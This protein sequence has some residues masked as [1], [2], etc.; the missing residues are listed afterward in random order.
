M[1]RQC[2]RVFATILA[3][4]LLFEGVQPLTAEAVNGVAGALDPAGQVELIVP[5]AL[6]DGGNYIFFRQV[7]YAVS[8][9]STE[10]LYLP[11]QRTGDLDEA[12][13]VTVKVIDMTARHG[14]NYELEI[15]RQDL[16]PE[17]ANADVSVLDLV[18]GAEEITEEELPGEAELGEIIY[19]AGGADIT[20]TE[21]NTI[22]SITATPLDEDGN[23]IP[24]AQTNP[25][26][27]AAPDEADPAAQSAA[28][29]G[30]PG[31]LRAAR[32]AYTGTASDRQELAQSD[33]FLP[34]AGDGALP[35]DADPSK[36]VEDA[37]PGREYRLRFEPGQQAL[38][39]VVTPLY[40]EEADGDS[41]LMLTLKDPSENVRFP[42]D[43]GPVAVTIVN[44]D[45]PE[46]VTI[47]LAEETVTAADGEAVIKVTRSGRLKSIAGVRIASWDGS[48]RQGKD[49]G[50]VGAELYF[51]MGVTERTIQLPVGHG[52]E[53]KDFHV[54]ITP[55]NSEALGIATARVV[56]PAAEVVEEEADLMAANGTKY[57]EEWNIKGNTF[58]SY[59]SVSWN[60]DY[61]FV[62]STPED[63]EWKYAG[64]DFYLPDRYGYFYDG[65]RIDHQVYANFCKARVY[66]NVWDST[67]HWHN[68]WIDDYTGEGI[69]EN[70]QLNYYYGT[71]LAPKDMGIGVLNRDNTGWA[72]TDDYCNV[73]VYSVK[74]IL[75][76]F[77]IT[78]ENAAPLRFEG[79]TAEEAVREY[80]AVNPNGDGKTEFSV[81]SGENFSIS[82]PAGVNHPRLVGVD[83]VRGSDGET[84]RLA[85]IDGKSDTV[86]VEL[87][88][89]LVD[90]L[91]RNDYITWTADST[92]GYPK[93]GTSYAGDITVRP[94][95]E[96]EDVT[97]EV[98]DTPYG[99]LK[100][101]G[102]TLA[103][104]TYTFHKG[105]KLVF[106]P[107]LSDAGMG[108]GVRAVGVGF[109]SREDGRSGA[110]VDQNTCSLYLA[111]TK[112]FPLSKYPDGA[113][114]FTLT[115]DYYD[116]WQV[117]SEQSNGVRVR[118]PAEE[119]QYFDT[120]RGLFAGLTP[121]TVQGYSVYTVKTNVKTNELTEL[122]AVTTD[123][124]SVPVWTLAGNTTLYSGSTFYFNTGAM[125]ED[126]LVTLR[127]DRDADT[128]AQYMLSGSVYSSTFNLSTGQKA[129]DRNP[130]IEALIS[131]AQTG[132]LRNFAVTDPQ[133]AF[134]MQAA[135][136]H[137]GLTSM[138]YLVSYNGST[139]VKETKLPAATAPAK[140]Y[141][142]FDEQG[143]SS[144]FTAVPVNV[145]AVSVDNFSR[146][147]AH[148]ASASMSQSGVADGL[149]NAM[150]M[151]G[152]ELTVR[153]K[154]DPGQGYLLDGLPREEKVTRVVLYFENQ[155]T[156]ERHGQFSTT[157][158]A[159]S[160]DNPKNDTG[161]EMA[162]DEAA[163]TAT[164]TINK[165]SPDSPESW[166]YGDVL[167]AQL[168]TDKRAGVSSWYEGDMIYDPVSTGYA[169][170]TDLDYVPETF[171]YNI[172]SLAAQLKYSPDS[173]LSEDST[174]YSFD[175][176][177][178]LGEITAA[179]H[180]FTTL[181][182]YT[183]YS[184]AKK[185]VKDLDEEEEDFD[186][187]N[188]TPEDDGL[189]GKTATENG[190]AFNIYFTIKKTPYGGVR[191]LIGVAFTTGA[192]A[193]YKKQQNPYKSAKAAAGMFATGKQEK[194]AGE[195]GGDDNDPR[196][197]NYKMIFNPKTRGEKTEGN[198]GGKYFTF[199]IYFG[200]YLDFG[201]IRETSVDGETGGGDSKT[202]E[203]VFMGAG[204]FVGFRGS[205]G[206][207]VP[208]M[209][210]PIPMYFAPE[211]SADVTFFIGAAANPMKTLKSFDKDKDHKGQD[212][213]F[214]IEVLG[215]IRA[216]ANIGIGVYKILG[217]RIYIGVG[218]DFGYGLNMA[219]W[220]PNIGEDWGTSFYFETNGT[221]D[222]VVT[223]IT[224]YGASV[225]IKG[226]GWLEYSQNAQRANRLI[227]YVREGIADGEGTAEA[228]EKCRGMADE[229]ADAILNNKWDT[230]TLDDKRKALLS[231][232]RDQELISSTEYWS[233]YVRSQDGV[234][235]AIIEATLNGETPE[236]KKYFTRDHVDS[237]WVAGRD[238]QLMSAFS[239][240]STRELVQ[241]AFTQTAAQIQPIG[242]NR[243]LVVFLDDDGSRDRQ[244]AAA[245]KYTIYNAADDSWAMEPK[246]LQN[247]GT[248]DSKP[249][250][251]DAGDKL[252]LSWAST[253]PEKYAA[254]KAAFAAELGVEPDDPKVTE[255]M[256]DDPARVMSQ[257]DIF[258]AEFPKEA[259]TFGRIEQ[260]TDDEFCDDYPQAIYDDASGDYIVMY[261][262]TAQ[263]DGA[264]TDN[265]EK[266]QDLLRVSPAPDKTYSVLAYMLCNG[267]ADAGEGYKDNS[268]TAYPVPA[269]WVRDFLY[270][271][272]FDENTKN[273]ADPETGEIT[274][275]AGFLRDY[276]GQRFLPSAIRGEDGEMTD[277]PIVDLTVCNGYN[278][279][280]SYAFTVDR[281]LNLESAEDKELYLQFYRFADHKTYVPV[282]IAGDAIQTFVESPGDGVASLGA[283]PQT[284]TAPVQ[285]DVGSPRLIRNEGSTWL[286]W[287][288][289]TA[290]LRY[291]NVSEMLKDK[292]LVS[293]DADPSREDSWTYAVREDGSFAYDP[294]IDAVYAPKV[295]TVDFNI[296]ASGEKMNL[297]DYQIVTDRDDNLY[298]VW[299]KNVRYK[300][301]DEVL[302]TYD[303]TAQEI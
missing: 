287:Q 154:V 157:D 54:T 207:N 146:D 1:K 98:R 225:P 292:V 231:Y 20:D 274:G 276:G 46:P 66:V 43:Y 303:A 63:E 67:D 94:V 246:I 130:A 6:R 42:Q 218:F 216:G 149:V 177:P 193:G 15:Y 125:G 117:F 294:Q 271:N 268:D 189:N 105:D 253:A 190:W 255:A 208:F 114:M 222:L 101:A 128:H 275:I 47:S 139:L 36:L 153:V 241:N 159:Y 214:N 21:G 173:S 210:G 204:G 180:L 27:H 264:Y 178:Y 70:Y 135:Q 286:F 71:P 164:L 156:G 134:T 10:K 155:Y 17:I 279:L 221:L 150:K 291:I 270:E 168:Y 40:S 197:L 103:A 96:H 295:E 65:V 49:Y 142:G 45:A 138:R 48:A 284:Y 269:G 85:T 79:M 281:D 132:E 151:N 205:F 76:K 242:G 141:T 37:Y 56:I 2:K 181:S 123:A 277:P 97:V 78:V 107:N 293:E 199:G 88:Q 31:A 19:S 224:L 175:D 122:V 259:E 158:K 144:E 55:L 247:D 280:A 298:V 296:E 297:T 194:A 200:V 33:S 185:I 299:T 129:T 91:G 18:R 120:D 209:A 25:Q 171:N 59:L 201:Y 302:G 87:T 192:G 86:K 245:L 290:N 147:G 163:G 34:D 13:E 95:F 57:G 169:V 69:R 176:F 41:E 5:E 93:Y 90:Y 174:Q 143:H 108:A 244:Q 170:Y 183:G 166:T 29:A 104:G 115:E 161:V 23:P 238:G 39:L 267:K 112:Q 240:V 51:P 131:G 187:E 236:P 239:P 9:K 211:A 81:W 11:V 136:T 266:L 220:F 196:S 167:M 234:I 62:A 249:S 3:L 212:F 140:T 14:V 195:I 262:K 80:M 213:S 12:A 113:R 89:D 58:N 219:E 121:E 273:Y 32:N 215:T 106:E 227:A 261:Y 82:R 162:W 116:F 285:V 254:L 137:V 191:F 26:Q 217:G 172:D 44:E 258:C 35:D 226:S 84:F 186:E 235:G 250:L 263:D 257:M 111:N 83:A 206:V 110:L 243:Y 179:V 278:G 300:A 72:W 61:S 22:G 282:K 38:F 160:P 265:Y 230:Q 77:N 100:Y 283:R 232:A 124:G 237:E 133:G 64:V 260:L 145:G 73:T 252:I 60:G 272:E 28:A 152:Q 182:S 52:P 53:E 202:G 251:I 102:K 119:L 8:E 74:P 68:D 4:L 198:F 289:D 233:A 127:A 109:I 288:E 165:F 248:A 188:Y 50:G 223:S 118:V 30:G 229:M 228:R 92:E 256:E 24:E 16:E 184:T 99:A 75:R 148:F 301:Q 203:M 126:N 7:P